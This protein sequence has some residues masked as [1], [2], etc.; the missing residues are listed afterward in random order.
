MADYETGM[1]KK[2]AVRRGYLS[3][4]HPAKAL[5]IGMYPTGES[6]SNRSWVRVYDKVRAGKDWTDPE[7]GQVY[8]VRDYIDGKTPRGV[9]VT[10]KY[11]RYLGYC[12]DFAEQVRLREE[13]GITCRPSIFYSQPSVD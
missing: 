3:V 6:S 7:T 5:P 10:T 8:H 2:G 12:P 11:G 9:V 4:P 1:T 13:G